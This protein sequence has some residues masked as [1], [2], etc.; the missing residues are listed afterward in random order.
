MQG[1]VLKCKLHESKDYI[2]LTV[3]SYG[4]HSRGSVH[5][6]EMHEYFPINHEEQKNHC[7]F[8]LTQVSLLT[9]RTMWLSWMEFIFL[10]T[11]LHKSVCHDQVISPLLFPKITNVGIIMFRFL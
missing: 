5:I 3:P 10:C 9:T 8:S 1:R 4:V 2:P 11:L 6:S 7:V